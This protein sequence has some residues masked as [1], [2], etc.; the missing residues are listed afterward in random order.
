MANVKRKTTGWNLEEL[1]LNTLQ[2]TQLTLTQAKERRPQYAENGKDVYYLADNKNQV[3]LHRLNRD[4]NQI[5]RLTN[6]L[7]YM[8]EFDQ[9]TS[10]KG[11]KTALRP[12]GLSK[13]AGHAIPGV[14]LVEYTGK[15]EQLRYLANPKTIETKPNQA[16]PINAKSLYT[17]QT[18]F[19]PSQMP[20]GE[21]YQALDSLAP[22][23]W[24]P[25]FGIGTN[26]SF[27]GAQVTG[28]DILWLPPL[29]PLPHLLFW[30]RTRSIWR[31]RGL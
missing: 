25:M 19:Q 23:G 8:V 31:C 24:F 17:A 4:K 9:K 1:D 2:W 29:E 7:G 12:H 20:S 5:E 26:L 3:E 11:S 28:R 21:D 13:A 10:K 22:V 14:F 27:L 15:K 30:H 6:S 16:Q 18:D